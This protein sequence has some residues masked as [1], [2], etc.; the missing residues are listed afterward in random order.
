MQ[1]QKEKGKS[2]HRGGLC[3]GAPPPCTACVAANTDCV[4]REDLDGRRKE[5][6]KRKAED[7]EHHR[8]LLG[9]LLRSIRWSEESDAQQIFR[10]IR[11]DAPLAAINASIDAEVRKL[12]GYSPG[13]DATI[14][15]LLQLRSE[16][17]NLQEQTPLARARG[18]TMSVEQ[19]SDEPLFRLTAKPWTTVTDDDYLVSHLTSLYFTW[20]N[21][22]M[23]PLHEPALIEAMEKGDS[24]SL[25][26]SPFLVNAMLALACGYSDLAGAFADPDD[27]E[28]WGEHFYDEAKRLWDREEGRA[29]LINLQG[30]YLLLLYCNMHGKDQLGWSTLS[31]MVQ[32]YQDLGLSRQTKIPRDCPPEAVDKLRAAMLNASWSVFVCNT[33]FA[34][35]LLKKPTLQPPTVRRPYAGEELNPSVQWRPYPRL[36]KVEPLYGNALFNAYCDFAEIAYEVALSVPFTQNEDKNAPVQL[37]RRLQAWHDAL[38]ENLRVYPHAP[39]PLFELHALYYWCALTLSEVSD[40]EPSRETTPTPASPTSAMAIGL[41]VRSSSLLL[42][43]EMM[44][45]YRQYRQ[46]YG[47]VRV[48]AGSCQT[49]AVAYFILLKALRAPAWQSEENEEAL[50]DLTA[51]LMMGARRWLVYAGIIRM[52]R[53]TA[54]S[55]GVQ[56]PQ[57]LVKMLDEFDK[58]VWTV[59]A[60]RRIKSV[61]PN[62][63]LM[64]KDALEDGEVTMGELLTK[65]EALSA[66]DGSE[67]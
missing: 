33:M 8:D 5:A 35:F 39:G 15:G 6:I 57:K 53:P 12:R 40:R 45:M 64:K 31:I 42:I 43:R 13:T 4:F 52:V 30:L 49:A 29:S 59:K 22:F 1:G 10:L 67:N 34:M 19:M 61:Y 62:L 48:M 36:E 11:D 37:L 17:A 21:T 9:G 60:H 55:I 66:E 65:W 26:C 18:K 41:T 14:D 47:L 2:K 63:A 32:M 3:S 25:L 51:Y 24:S 28:T 50:I 54:Q 44:P 56:L 58:T 38:P 16:A 7:A 23:H 20:W 27:P 46:A